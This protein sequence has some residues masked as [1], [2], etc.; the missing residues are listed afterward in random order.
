MTPKL[1]HSA[2]RHKRTRTAAYL[3]LYAD[4]P[5]LEDS[6]SSESEVQVVYV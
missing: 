1:A 3:E 4:I 6:V 5:E 2:R